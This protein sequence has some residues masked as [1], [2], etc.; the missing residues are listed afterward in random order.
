M[1]R[2]ARVW[3]VQY[4]VENAGK[5]WYRHWP[6]AVWVI[7]ADLESDIM[8]TLSKQWLPRDT[9]TAGNNSQLHVQYGSGK[10]FKSSFAVVRLDTM[11]W[12]GVTK[13]PR[14]I[15]TQLL[16][17]LLRELCGSAGCVT[18]KDLWRRLASVVNENLCACVITWVHK[19]ISADVEKE[20]E[21]QQH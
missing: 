2:G 15:F 20:Q 21:Q 9:P 11:A 17:S 12:G 8:N 6:S 19:M 7:I 4:N 14:S 10:K 1:N 3:T 5:W 13:V 16:V 18:A